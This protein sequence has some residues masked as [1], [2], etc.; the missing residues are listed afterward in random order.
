MTLQIYTHTCVAIITLT[1]IL[2]TLLIVV[3]IITFSTEFQRDSTRIKVNRSEERVLTWIPT[4]AGW[5]SWKLLFVWKDKFSSLSL[6]ID[7][8]Y[9][10][11]IQ[12]FLVRLLTEWLWQLDRCDGAGP[13]SEPELSL[14]ANHRWR[15]LLLALPLVLRVPYRWKAEPSK[16]QCGYHD[17]GLGHWPGRQ[18]LG[19]LRNKTTVWCRIIAIRPL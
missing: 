2:D 6:F 14:S 19:S 10:L 18:N 4:G 15:W 11:Y 12:Y 9:S 1:P 8:W 7:V 3:T 5:S 13:C 16:Y 17:A